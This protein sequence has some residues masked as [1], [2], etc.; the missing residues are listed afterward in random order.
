M[1]LSPFTAIQNPTQP[2]PGNNA[3]MGYLHMIRWLVQQQ[4]LQQQM[5]GSR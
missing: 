3:G 5:K 4:M 1:A 2:N